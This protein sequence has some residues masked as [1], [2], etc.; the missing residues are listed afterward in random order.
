[1]SE[2]LEKYKDRLNEVYEIVK[3]VEVVTK[4]RRII[5]IEILEEYGKGERPGISYKARYWENVTTNLNPTYP[6]GEGRL[7]ES[8]TNTQILWA[9]SYPEVHDCP[10]ADSALSQALGF[11]VGIDR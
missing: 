8:P 10:D 5:R 4:Q 6:G 11:V 7:P 3:T 1:M 9:V 2:I